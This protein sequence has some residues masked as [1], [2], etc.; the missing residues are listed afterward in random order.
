[1]FA[2]DRTA[3]IHP[4]TGIAYGVISV[5][6]LKPEWLDDVYTKGT[7]VSYENAFEEFKKELAAEGIGED[8]DDYEDK[9]QEFNDSYQES[10]DTYLFEE[11][12]D[13]NKLVLQTSSLGIY[14]IQSPRVGYFR[15][16]SPCCPNAGDLDAPGGSIRTYD[17][18]KGWR[19]GEPDER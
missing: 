10:E 8:H 1:M 17:I 11:G 4:E 5:S 19:R 16:C 7:N 14:V 6:S 15:Q 18:P 9:I 3:N 12:E 2:I 13:A